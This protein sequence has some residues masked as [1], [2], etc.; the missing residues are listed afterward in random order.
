MYQTNRFL[1]HLIGRWLVYAKFFT[2][3][4]LLADREVVPEFM[5]YFTSV[6]P[7]IQRVDA[8]L[9]DKTLLTRVSNELIDVVEPLTQK[10]AG[11]ETARIVAEM[12]R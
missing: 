4:N 8:Y 6:E 10:K 12:L 3:A 2:L 7:I 11:E 1:W 5:P 9:Q